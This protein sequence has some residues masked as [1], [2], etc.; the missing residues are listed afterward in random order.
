VSGGVA[1][2]HVSF[3]DGTWTTLA[4]S[5]GRVELTPQFSLEPS[6]SVNWFKSPRGSVTATVMHS[7][8]TYTFTP[9]MFV[10]GLLQYNS[11]AGTLGTNLRFRWEY[12]PGSELFLVY[13][14]DRHTDL[15]TGR[16][17]ALLSR[18]F[19]VKLNR[20]FRF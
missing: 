1:L 15:P 20:L 19:V 8:L 9:R 16:T 13:V 10:S 3:Y 14:D 12:S 11:S 17:S 7:R 5:S 2:T 6:A 18:G 4:F